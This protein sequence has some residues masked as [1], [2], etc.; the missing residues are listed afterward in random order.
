MMKYRAISN[1]LGSG[2]IDISLEA[3]HAFLKGKCE[4]PQDLGFPIEADQVHPFLKPH[5]GAGVQWAVRG[6]RRGLFESFGL[7]KTF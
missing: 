5:Q 2:R 7:G 6:G 3:Y 4:L 1:D